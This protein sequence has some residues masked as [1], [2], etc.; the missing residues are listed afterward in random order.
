MDNNE[1]MIWLGDKILPVNEAKINVLSPTSQFGLNVFEGIRC[2]WSDND[3]QLY[4]FRLDDH[5]KRLQQ[6]IK[7]MRINSKYSAENLK[8]A[9]IDTIKANN[10]KE[11]IAVRQTVF[12][13]GVGGT[14]N[15]TE[16]VNMFVAPIS[17]HFTPIEQKKGLKCQISS[18]ERISDRNL[19]PRAKV[20]ANYINSRMAYIEATQNGYDT[21]LLLNNHGKVSEGPGSCFFMIRNNQL[22]TPPITASILESITRDTIIKIAKEQ[23]GLEVI[24]RDIDR[25]ELYICDEAFL[26]GSAMEITH[27]T[28]IDGYMVGDGKLGEITHKLSGFYYL[29]ITGQNIQYQSWLTPIY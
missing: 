3:K 7:L 5:I 21:A 12:V 29:I 1:R 23:F 9:L 20:G 15:S 10:Y 26:C 6:S 18:W 11:D 4:A 8:N 19:S 27:I 13:D 2:Y 14:W 17:K 24:E 28:N 25:T 16:P 22:I